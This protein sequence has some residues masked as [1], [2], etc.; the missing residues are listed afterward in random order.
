MEEAAFSDPLSYGDVFA[1][2]G[3]APYPG[4]SA[5]SGP[6]SPAW[7]ARTRAEILAL[8]KYPQNWDTYGAPTINPRVLAA[9]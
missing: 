2:S 7:L 9:A 8:R 4:S 5:F 6:D 3:W 1:R